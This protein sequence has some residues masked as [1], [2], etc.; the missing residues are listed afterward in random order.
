MKSTALVA[1]LL[2]AEDFYEKE[3]KFSGNLLY[4]GFIR[5]AKG[6]ETIV[7]AISIL[8]K[9]GFEVRLD[10][11]GDGEFKDELVRIVRMK[12]MDDDIVF[13]GHI[14][15]RKR[16]REFYRKS[17]VFLFPSLSEGSPRVVL[18][19]MAN[20]LPVVS[21]PVGA[22]PYIFQNDK[23]IK[24][25]EFNNAESFAA[26]VVEYVSD[27]NTTKMITREAYREVRDYYTLER[28]LSTLFETRGR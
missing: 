6:L 19:A 7:D 26:K 23:H 13:H 11:V 25:A 24:Y 22:L 15:D 3:F 5:Y 10:I 18:E 12:D 20:S 14:S 17:D 2:T 1:S 28:F 16:L 8:K 27:A 4:V 21:T 9:M